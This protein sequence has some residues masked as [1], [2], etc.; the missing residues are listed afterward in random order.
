M[1][2]LVRVVPLAAL[3]ASIAGCASL[4]VKKQC[5]ADGVCRL[6]KNG[7]VSYEGPPDKVAEYQGKDQKKS[8]QAAALE[9]AWAEAPRRS[10]NEPI[11]LLVVGP[12]TEFANLKPF[13][14]T[15]RAMIEDAL[16]ADPRIQLVPVAQYKWLADE[17]SSGHSSFDRPQVR[18]RVD[19]GL[20]HRLR[21]GG[22]DVDVVVVFSLAAKKTSGVVSGGGGVGV[23]EVNNVEFTTSLSSVYQFAELATSQTG[24][25]TDSL[26]MVGVN[27]DGK[28]GQADLKSNRN[29]ERDRPAVTA[30]GA[31]IKR[32]VAEQVAPG[33]PSLAAAQQIRAQTREQ[34]GNETADA[35]RNLLSGGKK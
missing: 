3:L 6:E 14:A 20:T 2:R 10:A 35:L 28:K 15:Y 26:S 16:R 19:T 21:D 22:A 31:W 8:D 1:N 9:K 12:T 18:T 29:P 23:A 11:R 13:A 17:S 4:N 5:F 7:V 24:K 32:T 33:L 27:K 30:C 34:T 25:S